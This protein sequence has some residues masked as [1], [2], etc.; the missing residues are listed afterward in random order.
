MRT[1]MT[2]LAAIAL[3]VGAASM[4]GCGGDADNT[5]GAAGSAGNTDGG[6]QAGGANP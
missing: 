1:A 6:G 2:L 4:T 3:F 5:S